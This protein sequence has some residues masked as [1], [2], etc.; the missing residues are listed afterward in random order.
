MINVTKNQIRSFF[1][2]LNVTTTPTQDGEGVERNVAI[3]TLNIQE[4]TVK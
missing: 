1:F 4:H 2:Q 3:R